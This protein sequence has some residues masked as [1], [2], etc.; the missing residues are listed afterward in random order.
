ML[1]NTLSIKTLIAC[2]ALAVVAPAMAE[3][4]STKKPSFEALDLDRDGNISVGE[5]KEHQWVADNFT[6]FD[7]NKDGLITKQEFAR[8]TQ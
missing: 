4:A 8:L 5:A 2:A 1:K 3:E 6:I 7:A